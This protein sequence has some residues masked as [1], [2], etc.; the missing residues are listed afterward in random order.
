MAQPLPILLRTASAVL[1]LAL[2]GLLAWALGAGGSREEEGPSTIEWRAFF[3]DYVRHALKPAGTFDWPL[4]PPDGDGSFIA[5]AYREKGSLGETW[6]AEPGKKAD[7]IPVHAVADGWVSLADDFSS[8]WGFVVMTIH[9]VSDDG[10]PD[11]VEVMYAN[12]GRIAV[13]QAQFVSK[14]EVLGWLT[15]DAPDG[16]ALYFEIREEVGLGLGPS[17]AGDDLGWTKPSE[18]LQQHHGQAAAE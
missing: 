8:Q 3:Q 10:Y 9:R 12:L 13:R 15:P 5:K 17:D 14:G 2:F 4:F 16:Q 1:L 11:S 6:R 18:F 7:A